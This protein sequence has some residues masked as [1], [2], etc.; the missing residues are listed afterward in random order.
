MRVVGEH[1]EK[2]QVTNIDSDYLF[3]NLTAGHKYKTI[4]VSRESI[5]QLCS[6]NRKNTCPPVEKVEST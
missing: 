3:N 1:N 4:G 5:N 2:D 6:M